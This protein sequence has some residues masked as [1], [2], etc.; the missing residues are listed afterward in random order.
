METLTIVFG[1]ARFF[2]A[3]ARNQFISLAYF[4]SRLGILGSRRVENVGKARV[5]VV[6]SIKFMTFS[7][8]RRRP[9][10]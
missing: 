2:G 5:Q 3:Q 10:L 9:L 1:C 8:Q 6:V 4:A 7:G